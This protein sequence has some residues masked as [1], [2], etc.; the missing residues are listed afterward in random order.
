MGVESGLTE[1]LFSRACFFLL[2]CLP[3]CLSIEMESSLVESSVSL[4][5]KHMQLMPVANAHLVP[6]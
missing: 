3:L 6:T 4:F 5:G 2:L 1:S